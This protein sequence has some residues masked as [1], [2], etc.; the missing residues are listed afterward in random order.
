MPKEVAERVAEAMI[1]FWRDRAARHGGDAHEIDGLVVAISGLPANDQSV[2]LVEREPADARAALAEAEG[3]F[4]ARGRAFGVKVEVGRH[5]AVESVVRSLGLRMVSS[6][7]AM[8]VPVTEVG[9][10]ATPPGVNVHRVTGPD[11]LRGMVD[12]EVAVF[13]TDRRVAEGLLPP[14]I[15]ATDSIRCYLATLDGEPVGSAYAHRFGGALG[16]FGVA[17]LE[18]ARRRGIG[19]AVTTSAVRDHREAA[20][21]AWL[22]ASQ[23]GRPVYERMGFR[24]IS[25][26]EVW[27]RPAT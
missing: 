12:I 3:R 11:E 8:V 18:R 17:T 23:L 5:P 22:E 21:L 13:G 10:A 16:V 14:S 15:L 1:A 24:A 26:Y 4:R 2:T 19:T 27:V 6:E 7:P 25:D 20:D 9:P